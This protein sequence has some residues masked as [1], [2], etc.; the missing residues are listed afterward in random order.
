MERFSELTPALRLKTFEALQP[1]GE[2]FQGVVDDVKEFAEGG[3]S[4]RWLG[5]YGSVG[6]GKTHLG[7]AVINY[8]INHPDWD[9]AGKYVS[10]PD[11]LASLRNG[12]DNGTYSETVEF[13]KQVPLLM[14]DDLGTERSTPWADE[15]LFRILDHRYAQMSETI[16]TSNSNTGTLNARLVDRLRDARLCKIIRE[17]LPSYRTGEIVQA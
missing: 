15:Q 11:L 14:V 1:A 4:F 3:S 8:R 7:L 6:W 17:D 2:R 10:A 12:F 5:L 9:R 13:Y 16:T